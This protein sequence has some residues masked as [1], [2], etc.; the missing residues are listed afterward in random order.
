MGDSQFES[1]SAA[2]RVAL[3]CFLGHARPGGPSRAPDFALRP[4][5]VTS[6]SS[7]GIG[8]RAEEGSLTDS[9]TVTPEYHTDHEHTAHPASKHEVN[10]EAGTQR[11]HVVEK[12]AATSPMAQAV[13][14]A[15]EPDPESAPREPELPVHSPTGGFR[16][17]DKTVHGQEP[18]LAFLQSELCQQTMPL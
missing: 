8:N 10:S 15:P 14:R 17:P 11:K 13:P 1:W 12:A 2:S 4:Q 7:P 3:P 16:A 6:P 18:P 5:T 9:P